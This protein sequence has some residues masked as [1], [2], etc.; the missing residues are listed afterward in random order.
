VD[1]FYI[2]EIFWRRKKDPFNPG[3]GTEFEPLCLK[4][5]GNS[6]LYLE[7]KSRNKALGDEKGGWK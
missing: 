5:Y 3:K 2:G 7:K 4:G 6:S 1:R